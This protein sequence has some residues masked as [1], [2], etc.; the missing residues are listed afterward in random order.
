[1]DTLEIWLVRHGETT[2][3]RDGILAGWADLPLTERGEE[4]ARSVAPALAGESFHGVWSSDL[5]RAVTT[6]RLARGEPRTDARLREINFGVLEGHAWQTLD[7][8]YKQAFIEFNGFHPP[9]GE[10][11]AEVRTRVLAFLAELP[12]GRHLL[13]THGGVI[14]LLTRDAGHDGF[15]PTGTVVGLDLTNRRFLFER[16][17]PIP[18][19]LAFTE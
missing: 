16:T 1:V 9:G 19:P 14:R 3:S 13:F 10:S 11:L 5:V 8:A 7:P 17:C 2:A 4:Q 6:A 12:F 18:S 15:Q